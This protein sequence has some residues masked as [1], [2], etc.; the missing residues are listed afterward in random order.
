VIL[1][2]QEVVSAMLRMPTSLSDGKANL[3]QGAIGLAIDLKSGRITHAS[4]KGRSVHIH[5]DT[6]V[7]LIG[8]QL[9]HWEEAL[10][11]ARRASA[12]IPLGYIG[13]DICMDQTRGPLVLEVNGR[14][15]I[16]IQ[17]VQQR[18]LFPNPVSQELR[19]A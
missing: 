1:H 11:I 7:P 4:M 16:E 14:P 10:Q 18:G 15:G 13:I 17:N 9:P 8:L 2:K 6:R 3:H 5:P 12:A 19:Y